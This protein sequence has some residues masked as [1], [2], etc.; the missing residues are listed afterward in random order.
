MFQMFQTFAEILIY[1]ENRCKMNYLS[2]QR[3]LKD[4][5]MNAASGE[6]KI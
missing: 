1:M 3:Y 5:R 6:E 4:Y 2:S